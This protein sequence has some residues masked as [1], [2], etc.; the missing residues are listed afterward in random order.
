MSN[1]FGLSPETISKIYSVFKNYP[2]IEKAILYGTRAKGTY[3]TGSDIDLA[4]VGSKNLNHSLSLK[5]AIE[6]D[7]LLL[8]YEIDL[9]VLSEIENTDLVDHINRV[10]KIF[11]Q[12]K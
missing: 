4:L 7:D 12:K 8:P 10:G 5:I 9:A 1:E 3:K 2:E 11:Y 6:L